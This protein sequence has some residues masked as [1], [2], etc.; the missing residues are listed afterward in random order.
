[1]H[2]RSPMEVSAGGVMDMSHIAANRSTCWAAH[3]LKA[4]ANAPTPLSIA[5]RARAS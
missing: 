5:T 4:H 2:L 3:W 1:M